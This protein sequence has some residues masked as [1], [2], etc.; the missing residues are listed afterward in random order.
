LAFRIGSG[1]SVVESVLEANEFAKQGFVATVG[2]RGFPAEE[3][4]ELHL[5]IETMRGGWEEAVT[6]ETRP[7]DLDQTALDTEPAGARVFQ[8]AAND[9]R[10][11]KFIEKIGGHGGLKA[12]SRKSAKFFSKTSGRIEGWRMR[13]DGGR[14][15]KKRKAERLKS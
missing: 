14:I 2:V 15:K 5:G 4:V 8:P 11:G 7:R 6:L 9:V 1:E 12:V 13:E 10:T 3:L